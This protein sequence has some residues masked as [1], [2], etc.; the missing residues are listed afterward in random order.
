MKSEGLGDSVEKFTKATGIKSVVESIFGEDCGCKKRKEIL[1]EKF[2][3][4]N[5]NGNINR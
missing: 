5:K 1:N 3:Y 4:S 2:P